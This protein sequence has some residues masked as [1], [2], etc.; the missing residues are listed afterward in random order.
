MFA[1][2]MSVGS[3]QGVLNALIGMRCQLQES[4]PSKISK[5]VTMGMR[6]Y[7]LLNLIIMVST[8]YYNIDTLCGC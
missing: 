4:Y 3:V 8:Q 2:F 7:H 6:N 1:V 5:I